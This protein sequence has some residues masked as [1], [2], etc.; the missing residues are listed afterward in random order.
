M[1]LRSFIGNKGIC[2]GAKSSEETF[3]E[4]AIRDWIVDRRALNDRCAR[5]TEIHG[6]FDNSR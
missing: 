3:I 6:R 1:V 5:S 4:S 2:L